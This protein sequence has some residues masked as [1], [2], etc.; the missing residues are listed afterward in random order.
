MSDIAIR[1]AQKLLGHSDVMTR[2]IFTHV[3]NRGGSR[4]IVRPAYDL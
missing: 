1:T 4:G 2:T 3:L